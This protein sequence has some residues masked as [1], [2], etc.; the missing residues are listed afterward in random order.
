MTIVSQRGQVFNFD[1]AH[2]VDFTGG[3]SEG[4]VAKINYWL[5][6]ENPHLSGRQYLISFSLGTFQ[7][8]EEANKVHAEFIEAF[9]NGNSVY[10]VPK[11]TS[12]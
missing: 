7:T 10:R 3:E 2:S 11:E 5:P 6:R 9:E 12:I 8:K 4:Y 1:T